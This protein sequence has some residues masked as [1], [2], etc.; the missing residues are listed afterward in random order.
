MFCLVWLSRYADS[1]G[2]YGKSSLVDK[3]A[4][5]NISDTVATEEL[6]KTSQNSS[7]PR[8]MHGTATV[9]GGLG[10]ARVHFG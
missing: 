10:K 5:C 7:I 9:E 6:G 3:L 1:H 8:T 2:L 4:V